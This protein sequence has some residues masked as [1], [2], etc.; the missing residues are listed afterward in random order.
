MRLRT[1]VLG[2]TAGSIIALYYAVKAWFMAEPKDPWDD[3]R[4]DRFR[5]EP[6]DPSP[7][8]GVVFPQKNSSE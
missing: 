7:L 6:K 4:L 5:Q 2:I 3:V 1:K 8:L